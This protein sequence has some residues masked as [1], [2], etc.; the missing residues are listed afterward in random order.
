MRL[1]VTGGC[2]FAGSAFL[3]LAMELPA[4][5]V[6]NVDKLT[7]AGNPAAVASLLG[8]SRYRFLRADIADAT[9]IKAALTE[10]RPEAVVNFAA[11]THVDRSIDS[12]Q[13]F[14]H[15]N[16]IGTHS[17]LD[18]ATGYW[19]QLDSP[20][21]ERFRYLQVSTDEVYG[22]REGLPAAT[23]DSAYRPSS[24]YA[25]AKAAGDHLVLAWVRTHGIPALITHCTN[26]YGPWQHTEKLLP[27]I[28]SR[29]LAGCRLPVYGDGRQERDWIHV[30]DH[31]RGVLATLTR[32]QPGREYLLA[33]GNRFSNLDFVHL[34][35]DQLDRMHPLQGD[36]HSYRTLVEHVA[37]R[38]GHDRSYA[39]DDRPSRLELDWTPAIPFATGIQST[40]A[41]YMAA[42][43]HR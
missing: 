16:L 41:W 26:N 38:P 6:L 17:L 39:L 3:R 25:A 13:P 18:T 23:V 14:L 15:T 11:E 20:D 22:D 24:P 37:D 30:D 10:F 4:I 5:E 34:L 43:R 8:D 36:R 21:R 12:A 19:R 27:L 2:G 1:L 40:I 42:A 28:V 7:Y 33:G 32:G 35:C 9:T 29:A 31:A